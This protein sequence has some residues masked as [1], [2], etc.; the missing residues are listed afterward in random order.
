MC[1]FS[2]RTSTFPPRPARCRRLSAPVRG[3]PRRGTSVV[4]ET[5]TFG[6]PPS[7]ASHA[8]RGPRFS[9][10][11]RANSRAGASPWERP[12]PTAMLSRPPGAMATASPGL[13]T[14]RAVVSAGM[15]SAGPSVRSPRPEQLTRQAAPG[16]GPQRQGGAHGPQPRP[17][18]PASPPSHRPRPR[19]S[20]SRAGAPGGIVSAARAWP[21]RPEARRRADGRGSGRDSRRHGEARGGIRWRP[22]PVC[23]AKPAPGPRPPAR[24]LAL[25]CGPRADS[26]SPRGA[27]ADPAPTPP[28]H[29]LVSRRVEREGGLLGLR[30]Y[31]V[32]SPQNREDADSAPGPVGKAG[33]G[34]GR[35][36]RKFHPSSCG[37]GR[38]CSGREVLRLRPLRHLGPGR[39]EMDGAPVAP[40]SFL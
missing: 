34:A 32:A 10:F 11:S 3:T 24:A 33:A 39:S 17:G 6:L 19:A 36:I 13:A 25:H 20:A 12:S 5:R 23:C 35:A 16:A 21:R 4:R 40:P 38:G 1:L 26:S 9:L 15:R 2:P 31:P 27:E 7:P 30:P 29:R 18:A 8:G 37:A 14:H 28:P 22:R